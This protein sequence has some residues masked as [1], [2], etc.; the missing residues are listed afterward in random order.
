MDQ[1]KLSMLGKALVFVW[2]CCIQG[3][4]LSD[5]TKNLGSKYFYRNEGGGIKEIYHEYPDDG[6]F[7]PFYSY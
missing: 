4:N 1:I 7:I 5:S 2:M 6:G 3:C